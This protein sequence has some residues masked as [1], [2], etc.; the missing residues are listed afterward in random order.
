MRAAFED[1]EMPLGE[2]DLKNSKRIL[3]IQNEV[4]H[5]TGII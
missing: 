2:K 3:S 5:G 4:S 1:D